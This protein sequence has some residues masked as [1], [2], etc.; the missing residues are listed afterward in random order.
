MAANTLYNRF[1]RQDGEHPFPESSSSQGS[2]P[3]RDPL[4]D[5]LDQ[6]LQPNDSY[7]Q[8]HL[9]DQIHESSF[10]PQEQS[11]L[12]GTIPAEIRNEIFRLALQEYDDPNKPYNVNSY[13]K[14]P[15]F[16][17][18]TRVDLAL[19]RTC[20]R[21]WL[22]TR[23]IPLRDLEVCF[24]LGSGE[25]KPPE[26]VLNHHHL[27]F[28]TWGKTRNATMTRTQ[29]SAVKKIR[30]IPQLYTFEP[31]II[32]EIFQPYAGRNFKPAITRGTFQPYTSINPDTVTITLRYTDWWY[33]E[34]NTPLLLSA[35]DRSPTPVTN[36]IRFPSSVTKIV[37]ELETMEGKRKEL[38]GIVAD[39]VKRP[40]AWAYQ[41]DDGME[42]KVKGGEDVKE[43]KWEGPTTYDGKTFQHH[44]KGEKMWYVVKVLTWEVVKEEG[45]W[46]ST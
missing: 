1:R 22:E 23:A 24:Y 12:F 19:L 36:G 15:G 45:A 43:W 40:D 37:M 20:K 8:N 32:H 27:N 9:L 21:V 11:P 29:W 42:L 7:S 10:H 5:S 14:R 46:A 34:T 18:Q 17:G 6:L 35:N 26:Y 4:D 2:N 38:E 44:P 31:A 30:I 28:R 41:R 13:H 16:G 3:Q 39:I 25:R 33:W